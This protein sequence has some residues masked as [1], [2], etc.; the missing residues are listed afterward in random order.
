MLNETKASMD[1]PTITPVK[2]ATQDGANK[3]TASVA[4]F[5][6]NPEVEIA[7]RR[8]FSPAD[9]RRILALADACI[10]PGDIGA[11]LRREG[12]Y[13]SNLSTWRK[14]RAAAELA[15]LEPN[16]RGPKPN[17]A[18]A[19]AR[20]MEQL[21]RENDRLRH[22]LAQAHTIIDVQKKVS[23]LLGLLTMQAPDVKP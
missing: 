3:A 18:L 1:N 20:H 14:Q 12:L 23:A 13:S 22:Q 21:I 6:P 16:K 8:Q 17:P 10:S 9:K 11:L 4:S 2:D 5:T 19:E 7:R 15:A